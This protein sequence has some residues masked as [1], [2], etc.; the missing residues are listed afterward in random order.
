MAIT[1][2]REYITAMLS[3][4][5][6]TE[7]DV[8]LLVAEHP[9]LEGSL[10]VKACKI[11]MYESFSAILVGDISEGGYSLSWDVEKLKFWYA[12]LCREINKPSAIRP[13]IRNCSNFW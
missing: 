9:E 8:D 13:Q 6:L 1:T 4:F 3:R 11:A 2:N 12:S 7:S 10:D 5:G